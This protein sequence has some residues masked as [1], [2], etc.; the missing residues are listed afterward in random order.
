MKSD[1]SFERE[2]RASLRAS[3]AGQAPDELVARIGEIPSR[4]PSRRAGVRGLRLVARLAVNLAAAAV[5][6]IAVAALIVTRNG[7]SFPAGGQPNGSASAATPGASVA[8]PP[9]TFTCDS[10]ASPSPAAGSSAPP[11]RARS[12][13][14]GGS[15]V[16]TL[17]IYSGRP[18]PAWTLTVD[19]AAGM[20]AALA[21]LPD[22]MGTPPVGGLGYH[23]FT[24][25]RPGSTLVA[26]AG[27]VAPPGDGTRAMKA[28]P[29]RSVEVC[30]LMTSKW[31]VTPDEYAIA[32]LGIVAPGAAA[33][34]RLPRLSPRTRPCRR[35][36]RTRRRRSS[37]S[38]RAPRR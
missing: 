24:I 26:Y 14:P 37:G 17:G 36:R 23:G 22:G 38:C 9:A 13:T 7:G 35:R 28:D 10:P 32:K 27:A 2:V 11:S 1:E 25:T 12:V 30:L 6:V 31:H 18:D 19:E 15:V 3:A 4:E 16:V 33:L 34:P 20:D 21:V 8:T 29:T 5:V